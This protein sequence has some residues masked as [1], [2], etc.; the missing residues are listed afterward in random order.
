MCGITV[1]AT[2]LA[3][4]AFAL[5]LLQFSLIFLFLPT[6]GYF[7]AGGRLGR[8]L[9]GQSPQGLWEPPTLP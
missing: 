2:I 6:F 9:H 8:G 4:I 5:G 7:G 3:G 1:N